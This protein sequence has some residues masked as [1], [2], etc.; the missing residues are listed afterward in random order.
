M[1]ACQRPQPAA[2][3]VN[4]VEDPDFNWNALRSP[5]E[6]TFPLPATGVVQRIAA[7]LFAKVQTGV[8]TGRDQREARFVLDMMADWPDMD[9]DLRTRVFQRLNVY[10]IVATH[11]WPT[12]IAATAASHDNLQ[13]FLPPGV[14]PVV[15]PR[16]QQQRR[17]GGRRGNADA[18][19][20]QPVEPP[21]AQPAARG[22]GGG[23]RRN[24]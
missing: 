16:Q 10:A 5:L 22:G 8:L 7:G 11:G 18:A 2:A 23:R 3:A 15:Q 20:Q 4:V 24:N 1:A 9:A 14:Q 13:C 19:A 21:P 17:G 6:G 12:A